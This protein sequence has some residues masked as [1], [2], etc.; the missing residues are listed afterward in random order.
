MNFQRFK[1]LPAFYKTFSDHFTI[2]TLVSK[3]FEESLNR[4]LWKSDSKEEHKEG[5][6][7]IKDLR[8]H[9]NMHEKALAVFKVCPIWAFFAFVAL[10]DGLMYA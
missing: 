3:F 8:I 5:E 4:S 9:F 2:H 1:K 7:D 10:L 6:I